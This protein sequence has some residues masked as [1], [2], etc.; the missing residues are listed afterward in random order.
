MALIGKQHDHVAEKEVHGVDDRQMGDVFQIPGIDKA[1]GIV[2]ADFGKDLPCKN[3]GDENRHGCYKQKDHPGEEAVGKFRG[4]RS[5][6]LATNREDS[7][8]D[9]CAEDGH[10]D[11]DSF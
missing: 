4:I 10:A 1:E 5:K 3:E 2:A 8:V 9:A 7:S 11:Y 6:A